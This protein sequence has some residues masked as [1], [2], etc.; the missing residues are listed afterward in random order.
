MSGACDARRTATTRIFAAATPL[1]LLFG[2]IFAG[3]AA[4]LMP[5]A[6]SQAQCGMDGDRWR[7]LKLVRLPEGDGSRL[8]N[9]M[10]GP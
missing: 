9:A 5:R 2:L 4:D 6:H 10:V 1:G 8:M 3:F 7:W